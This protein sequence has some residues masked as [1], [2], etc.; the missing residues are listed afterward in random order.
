MPVIEQTRAPVIVKGIEWAPVDRHEGTGW[1]AKGFPSFSVAYYGKDENGIFWGWCALHVGCGI[2]IKGRPSHRAAM[3]DV[4]QRLVGTAAEEL[5]EAR[6][7][8][9]DLTDRCRAIGVRI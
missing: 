8:L 2:G 7:A 1:L 3:E 4:A 5:Q 6:D 9:D